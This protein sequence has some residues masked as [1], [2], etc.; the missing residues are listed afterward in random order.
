M[1]ISMELLNNI[2]T[3]KIKL[4]TW[5]IK[6]IKRQRR[7]NEHIWKLVLVKLIFMICDSKMYRNYGEKK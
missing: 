5:K 1:K 3:M 7:K 6:E 2:D 4:V